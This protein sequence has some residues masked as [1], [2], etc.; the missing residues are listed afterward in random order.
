MF[1]PRCVASLAVVVALGVASSA[2]GVAPPPTAAGCSDDGP[3]RSSV[4]P[5]AQLP[6]VFVLYPDGGIRVVL[7]GVTQVAGA[8]VALTQPGGRTLA[9][10]GGSG[11]YSCVS[12]AYPTSRLDVPGTAYGRVLLR[13]HRTLRAQVELRLLNGSGVTATL[14]RVGVIRRLA[15]AGRSGNSCAHRCVRSS[16]LVDLRPGR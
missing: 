7:R 13:R 6:T 9:S 3:T 4:A 14:R 10:L 16:G 11:S 1:L 2:L 12:T 5:S 8:T 15:P